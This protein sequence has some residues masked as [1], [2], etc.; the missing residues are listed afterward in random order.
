MG[1][2]LRATNVQPQ[3]IYNGANPQVDL[4]QSFSFEA[5]HV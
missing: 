3:T 4:I 2:E 1:D 5:P